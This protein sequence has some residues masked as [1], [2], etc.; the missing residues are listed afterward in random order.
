MLKQFS[1]YINGSFI[2]A[3]GLLLLLLRGAD[4]SAVKY[5]IVPCLFIAAIFAV[6]TALARNRKQVQFAYH[7][8]HGFTLVLY[9]IALLFFANSFEKFNLFTAFFFFFYAVSE[10]IFSI[11]L[12]NL[13]GKV[14]LGVVIVRMI[15][16]LLAGI[17]AIVSLN[18]DNQTGTSFSFGIVF[19]L[20]GVNVV[21]YQPAMK[22]L[23]IH[24]P[25]KFNSV[26]PE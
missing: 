8:T 5:T 15:I 7:E 3:I 16:G 12:F 19:I 11:W 25:E 2:I 4:L 14:N 6:M 10:I 26:V 21:L 20:I 17:G 9:A 23:G 18:Y 1:L 13:V 24:A 22:P